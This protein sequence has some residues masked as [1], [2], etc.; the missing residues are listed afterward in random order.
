MLF[1]VK[2][3]L[4]LKHKPEILEVL[5][6][7]TEAKSAKLSCWQPVPIT[8]E[9]K[10]KTFLSASSKFQAFQTNL[11]SYLEI[12]FLWSQVNIFFWLSHWESHQVYG[13]ELKGAI[14]KSNFIYR[15][16]KM[17]IIESFLKESRKDLRMKNASQAEAK[18]WPCIANG[19]KDGRILS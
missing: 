19:K 6:S 1:R 7:Q 15:Q 14:R 4:Q 3:P 13:N 17:H 18:T 11:I 8:S 16:Q 5:K 9:G 10:K 12:L 2:S